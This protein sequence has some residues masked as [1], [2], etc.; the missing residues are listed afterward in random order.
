MVFKRILILIWSLDDRSWLLEWIHEPIEGLLNN[1]WILSWY[2]VLSNCCWSIY[3]Q[4]MKLWIVHYL[5][6]MLLSR[7]MSVK[8]FQ[9]LSKVIVTCALDSLYRIEVGLQ[10]SPIKIECV[11]IHILENFSILIK[12]NK[13]LTHYYIR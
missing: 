13:W 2:C 3:C 12:F 8:C 1:S 7:F 9:S 4:S 5:C 6:W 10:P 11:K